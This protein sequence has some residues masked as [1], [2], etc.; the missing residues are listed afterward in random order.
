MHDGTRHSPDDFFRHGALLGEIKNACD[1]AHENF[2]YFERR[3]LATFS[4]LGEGLFCKFGLMVRIDDQRRLW[5]IHP[6]V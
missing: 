2:R 4:S 1:A 5:G 6:I 3:P